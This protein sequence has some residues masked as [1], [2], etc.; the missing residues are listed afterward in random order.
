MDDLT[1]LAWQ[2]E[3]ALLSP[4][5]RRSQ[6]R[7]L[8]LLAPDFV[9]IGQSGRRWDRAEVVAALVDDIEADPGVTISEREARAVAPDTV[10][11]TYRLR[12]GGRASLRSS[13]W[14]LAGESVQCVFHQGTPAPL[15]DSVV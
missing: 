10:L 6:A 11:L 3:E 15:G 4:A 14:R 8:E 2:G 13:L 5:V 12:F 7:L 1:L 9:E